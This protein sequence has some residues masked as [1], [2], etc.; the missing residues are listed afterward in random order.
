[1][2]DSNVWSDGRGRDT[3]KLQTSHLTS[4]AALLLRSL[5]NPKVFHLKKKKHQILS[6]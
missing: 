2:Q 5:Y 1:M 6:Q 4:T 3:K